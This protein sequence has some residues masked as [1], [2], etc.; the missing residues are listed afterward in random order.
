[1][2]LIRDRKAEWEAAWKTQVVAE[3]TFVAA[4]KV[5]EE[6]EVVTREAYVAMTN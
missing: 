1:M 5:M 2:V 6:A 3:R 4:K